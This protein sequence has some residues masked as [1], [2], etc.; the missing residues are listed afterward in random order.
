[1]DRRR[2]GALPVLA[3]LRRLL[4]LDATRWSACVES[5]IAL[6]ET[7]RGDIDRALMQRY[8]EGLG[9][10][11]KLNPQLIG[12]VRITVGSDVYDGSVR[13]RLNAVEGSF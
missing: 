11:F 3:H 2:G 5:A 10:T 8:G 6:D 7:E 13:A 12:G 9:T 4:R 1:M